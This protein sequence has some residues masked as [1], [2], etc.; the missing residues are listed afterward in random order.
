MLYPC[1]VFCNV[2]VFRDVGK[3]KKGI[4]Q[5][6][7]NNMS[8]FDDLFRSGQVVALGEVHHVDNMGAEEKPE[9]GRSRKLPFG[10]LRMWR[11]VGQ[12]SPDLG[13]DG[14]GRIF[15]SL[16]KVFFGKHFGKIRP[17]SNAR[18]GI[19]HVLGNVV[20]GAELFGNVRPKEE[21]GHSD[22][23]WR[24]PEAPLVCIVHLYGNAK[25]DIGLHGFQVLSDGLR[26]WPF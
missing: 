6:S 13:E 9:E 24:S 25:V 3:V 16:H 26:E 20:P 10:N 5:D 18:R 2:G 23:V 14:E 4:F 7:L 11:E 12:P 17:G 19:Q 22:T 21:G 8:A 15:K 1:P